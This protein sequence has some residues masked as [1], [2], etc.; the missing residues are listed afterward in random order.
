[1][2]ILHTVEFYDPSVGG[3]QE[4]VK[5]ISERLVKL[6]HDVTV[7]TTKLPGRK[8]LNI[9][10]VKIREFAISGNLVRGLSG[11]TDK[12]QDFLINSEFDVMVNFAAQQWATDLAFEVLDRVKAKKVF[13]PTGFSGLYLPEYKRYFEKMGD[14][15]K[16]YD[17]NVFLSNDYR[18]INF[19][20]KVGVSPKKTT[21]IPNGA[22]EDEFLSPS[23]TDIRKKLGIPSNHFLI[24]LVGSHT[25]VKGHKEAIE[26]FSRAKIKNAA[27]LIVGNIFGGGCS[28]SCPRKAFFFNLSPR[29]WFPAGDGKRLIITE[30]S[31]EETVAAY[32]SADL[33][34][35]P[36]NIECSPIVLFEAM[37]SRTPFLTADVGNSAEI[38]EW[39]G[40][41]GIVLPT[42]KDA[43]G[44]ARV[45]IPGSVE[46]LEEIYHDSVRRQKMAEAG[47]QAWKKRFTWEKIALEY[48]SL[49]RNLLKR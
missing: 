16:K 48:E 47:F 44:F 49:Y 20:R 39:S 45:R 21:I 3:M 19:A 1:M 18:D 11:E 13:V 25:G 41:A 29:R 15:M 8:S 46:I 34:L 17:M 4:V 23:G 31:R 32:Q 37:A 30:L 7:A 33:F 28:L 38:V 27:L 14:W 36:S 2:K 42:D 6:G 10:G 40:G 26:I 43:Q 5:Q 22:G 12:Y 9:R 35:F 24:L